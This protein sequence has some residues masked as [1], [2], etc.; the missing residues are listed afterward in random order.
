MS[1]VRSPRKTSN[2]YILDKKVSED[3]KLSWGARGLLIF[4][5][6]KP[7][8]WSVSVENLRKET[9]QSSRPTG[10]DGTY[11][12]LDELIAV[13][14]VRRQQPSNPD[15]TFASMDYVVFDVTVDEDE[16]LPETPLT[17]LPDTDPPHTVD[18]TLVSTDKKLG[19]KKKVRTEAA[20]PDWL[21]LQEW[22]DFEEMRVKIKKP[23]TDRA[24]QLIVIQLEKLRDSGH[25]PSQVLL[26]SV[27]NAWS[28]VFP[29]KDNLS[30]SQL[31][32]TKE[33]PWWSSDQ[34]ILKKA[35]EL[36]MQ[37]RPGESWQE[38]R[39]RINERLG[40]AS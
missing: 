35:T 12:L 7:D 15:G 2:F 22:K 5:L 26:A 27:V 6:G 3:K 23:L 10:R 31:A 32:K 36:G 24:K 11:I 38:L 4:L 37:T 14:Y 34:G 29:M 13:G 30:S 16:P 28:G 40:G 19:L 9:E 8:H 33:P 17:A 21:P 1:I 20:L 18:P 25:D 39:G